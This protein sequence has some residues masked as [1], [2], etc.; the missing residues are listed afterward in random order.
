MSC[1]L[2][3]NSLETES[4]VSSGL[5][6]WVTRA[7][8]VDDDPAFVDEARDYLSSKGIEI[9]CAV[10]A[11]DAERRF[12][13][14]DEI[15]LVITDLKMPGGGGLQFLTNLKDR[16]G[17]TR[18]YEAI[19]VTGVGGVDAA[20]EALRLE[21]VDFITKPVSPKNLLG[22]ILKAQEKAKLL[23]LRSEKTRALREELGR[24]KETIETVSNELVDAKISESIA[25]R[26]K[27][28]FLSGM[29]H[30]F[31]TPLNAIVGV[32]SML[33]IKDTAPDT[34]MTEQ[35]TEILSAAASRLEFLIDG[36]LNYASLQAGEAV[37]RSSSFTVDEFTE[38]IRSIFAKRIKDGDYRFVMS[39]PDGLARIEADKTKLTQAVG[40]LMD[41]AVKFSAIGSTI[42]L[43]VK[44]EDG[45]VKIEVADNGSGMTPAQLVVALEPFRQIDG[46]LTRAFEGIGLGLPLAKQIVELHQGTLTICSDLGVGT[47]VSIVIPQ[48][49]GMAT[50]E[51]PVA[52]APLS[53][54]SDYE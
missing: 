42:R 48:S 11:E 13:L 27:S 20:V 25:Q 53:K 36:I 47:T 21:V 18:V 15:N 33:G 30:E 10:C 34:K 38:V 24:R 35:L 37:L 54:V 40:L 7:L 16:Y 3:A 2:S 1:A 9:E 51:M 44:K 31:R 8:L 41:N 4:V 12:E 22:A 50:R 45:M 14:N 46:G 29:S 49:H 5:E 26:V 39:I 17:A 32:A 52:K 28:E 43:E 23:Y 6:P 19:V